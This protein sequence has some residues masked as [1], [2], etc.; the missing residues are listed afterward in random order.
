MFTMNWRLAFFAAASLVLSHGDAMA[1]ASELPAIA[2]GSQEIFDKSLR[3]LTILLVMAVLIENALAVVFNWRVFLTYFS[4]RGVRTIISVAVSLF[5]VRTFGI[6]VIAS[7]LDVYSS[8][9]I[10]TSLPSQL[11]TAL[12]LS[13]GSSG[14]NSLMASL[15]YRSKDREESV[16][17]KLEPT[18]AW[19]SVRVNRK[20]SV[21][22]VQVLVTKVD[23]PQDQPKPGAIAGTIGFRRPSLVELLLRNAN[24]FPGNGGHE[25]VPDTVYQIGVIGRDADGKKLDDPLAGQLYCFAPRAIVDFE[26]TLE[27]CPLTLPCR[28]SRARYR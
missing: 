1:Q 18:Q 4:L 14:V 28:L 25:V 16:V 23:L 15:G 17:P 3:A 22:P 9:K 11:L 27:R 13:G 7:L 21:G 2:L 8:A 12:I 24:R 26:V 5:I 10:T 6:D 20:R 19:L